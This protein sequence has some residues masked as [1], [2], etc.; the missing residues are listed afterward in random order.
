M[1]LRTT[2][3]RTWRKGK[4]EAEIQAINE[5][6]GAAVSAGWKAR[7]E[8]CALTGE[9]MRAPRG[10]K[11]SP[12]ATEREHDSADDADLLEGLQAMSGIAPRMREDLEGLTAALA[13]YSKL[14]TSQRGTLLRW[15]EFVGRKPWAVA[16]ETRRRKKDI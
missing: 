11:G 15:C 13:R 6:R 2:P 12:T 4:T 3:G 7:R 16:A 9:P 14:T 10:P 1:S 5:K 8:R